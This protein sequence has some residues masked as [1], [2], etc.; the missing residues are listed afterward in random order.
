MVGPTA[1]DI[2]DKEDVTTNQEKLKLVFDSARRLIP[3]ISERFIITAFAGLRPILKDNDDFYINLSKK[4]KN[5]IQ[6]AGIQSPG[7]TAAPAIGEYVK[8]LLLKA[9]LKM[10]A[11]SNWILPEAEGIKIRQ[12]S[13]DELTS[14]LNNGSPYSHIVCRCENISEGEILEAI[15]HGH[16]T[17]DSIKFYTRAEMGRCQGGFCQF[18]IMEIIA[19]E[20]NT[21][22]NKITKKGFG[23]YVVMKRLGEKE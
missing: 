14:T 17:L 23:S 7:L 20:T 11:K 1:D 3:K 16:T 12:L 9:G 22:Y 5:F 6:V 4:I 19:R 10:Q 15:K 8:D 2:E 18:K 21:A 13:T